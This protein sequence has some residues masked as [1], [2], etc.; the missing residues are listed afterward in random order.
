MTTEQLVSQHVT[1]T[2]TSQNHRTLTP[3]GVNFLI[4]QSKPF[5]KEK[6][7][8][9]DQNPELSYQHSLITM[10]FYASWTKKSIKL[11]FVPHV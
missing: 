1:D 8:P 2:S 7:L 4:L 6:H 3:G 5:F 11:S 10:A 9:E